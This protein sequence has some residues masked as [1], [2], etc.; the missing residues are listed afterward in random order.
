MTGRLAKGRAGAEAAKSFASLCPTLLARKGGARP[1]MRPQLQHDRLGDSPA[2]L[3]AQDNDLGWNDFG[4]DEPRA[5]EP[6][7]AATAAPTADVIPI[8]RDAADPV[9]TAMPTVVRQRR[10]AEQRMASGARRRSALEA[11]RKAA[12]TL[13]LDAERHLKLRLACTVDARSAQQV[14]TEA[15]DRLL[16]EMPDIAALADHVGKR[17]KS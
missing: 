11:G 7:R 15:L 4:E 9:T 3:S 1:A 6:A 17:T 2:G 13:R 5:L 8:G 14:V 10:A 16:A 12:F